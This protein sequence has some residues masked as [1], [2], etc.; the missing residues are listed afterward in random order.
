MARQVRSIR[1][2]LARQG[3]AIAA[4]TI[5]LSLHDS[6]SISA[7][8][9]SPPVQT[10][11]RAQG[12]TDSASPRTSQRQDQSKIT[13]TYSP[14]IKACGASQ[15]Q[16][17]AIECL[18]M[19]EAR[20]GGGQ[21]YASAAVIDSGANGKKTLRVTLP[22]GVLL[23][24]GTR[25]TI[26]QG[27]LMM[28]PFVICFP[29]GCMSDYD[30]NSDAITKLKDGQRLLVQARDASGQNIDLVMPL[31]DFAKVYDGPSITPSELEER[32]KRR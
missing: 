7:Q 6:G 21:I 9:N 22:L 17:D 5:L 29:S 32:Q 3:L 18:T 25:V 1:C 19:T 10:R 27:T 20:L 8:T 11:P 30:L 15:Q 2:W 26:D 16:P 23:Q 24:P 28:K 12:P 14:W 31:G 13:V 4:L